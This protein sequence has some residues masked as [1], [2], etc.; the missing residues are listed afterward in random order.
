MDGKE[1]VQLLL[2]FEGVFA[3]ILILLLLM[4]RKLLLY[5]LEYIQ[6]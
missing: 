2:A 6:Q 3:K 5:Q 4:L 1:L